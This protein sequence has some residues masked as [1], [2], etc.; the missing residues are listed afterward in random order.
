YNSL[1]PLFVA[2]ATIWFFWGMVTFIK[3]ADEPAEREK[4]RSRMIWGVI[5]L[6]VILAVW[7]LVAVLGNTFG[8]RVGLP[9]PP[10]SSG[11][12]TFTTPGED[13]IRLYGADR[14]RE[15]NALP[16]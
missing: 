16:F 12:S 1:V 11:S 8:I 15:L 14:C 13:C 4:G 9:G 10:G 2:L 5:A 7:G 3:K 6:F